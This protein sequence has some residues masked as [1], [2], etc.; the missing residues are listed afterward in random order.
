MTDQNSHTDKP[1]AFLIGNPDKDRVAESLE[2]VEDIVSD[3]ACIV[4]K[5]LTK[6]TNIVAEA[7]PDMVVVLGGDGM[8]LSVVRAMGRRQV[9]IVGVNLGK[10]GYLAEFGV[11]DLAD[12]ISEIVKDSLHVSEGMMLDVAIHRGDEVI[13]SNLAMNDCVVQAGPPFRMIELAVFAE[14]QPLTNLAADGLI[15]STPIGS[16]AHNMAAGGPILQRGL[17]AVVMTPICPHSFAHRPLVLRSTQ[18][19]EVIGIRVNEGTTV[20]LDGQI[21]TPLCELDRLVIRTFDH[22]FKLVRHPGQTRWHTLITKL[23]WGTRPEGRTT[24]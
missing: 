14:G 12:H 6:D 9:P 7:S 16:T 22:R 15:F 18:A 13:F 10:L 5:A 3:H 4:G 21:S 17:D 23:K 20:S 2:N 24:R 1:K 19:I 8:I 11:D